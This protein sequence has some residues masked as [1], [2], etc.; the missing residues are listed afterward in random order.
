MLFPNKFQVAV[1]DERHKYVGKQ[2]EK[3]GINAFHGRESIIAINI[4][5]NILSR[6]PFL[7]LLSLHFIVNAE[8]L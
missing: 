7:S 5:A 4:G 6:K 1:P 8:W 2:Q 3:D